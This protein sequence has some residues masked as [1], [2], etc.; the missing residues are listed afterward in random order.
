M[1]HVRARGHR[2][3]RRAGAI[4]AEGQTVVDVRHF[5][6]QSKIRLSQTDVTGGDFA[7]GAHR[8]EVTG[9]PSKRHD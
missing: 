3:W 7:L 4:G 8:I 9:T 1:K 6:R 5:G 2:R